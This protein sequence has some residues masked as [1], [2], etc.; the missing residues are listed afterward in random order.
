MVI[1]SMKKR[2][3]VILGA[4]TSVSLGMPSM[5][6][7]NRKM[8]DWAKEWSRVVIYQWRIGQSGEFWQEYWQCANE[9]APE[10]QMDR[11]RPKPAGSGSYIFS[12]T[13]CRQMFRLCTN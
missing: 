5:N 10:L 1:A 13:V 12:R 2:L 4:G 11:P 8:E 6:Q 7:L 3:L 9:C